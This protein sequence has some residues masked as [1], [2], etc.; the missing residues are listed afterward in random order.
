MGAKRAREKDYLMCTRKVSFT[1][2]HA[3]SIHHAMMMSFLLCKE[4]KQKTKNTE[5]KWL[6]FN[7]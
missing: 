3:Y 7:F 6:H 4:N 5:N 1:K 2:L